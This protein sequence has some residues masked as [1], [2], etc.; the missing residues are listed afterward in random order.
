MSAE[1]NKALEDI[2][3]EGLNGEEIWKALYNKELNCKKNILEYIDLTRLLKKG[4]AQDH[5]LEDTYS[6]IYTKIE[7]M[8]ANIKPNTSMYLKNQLKKQ[9]GK[10]VIE[11]DPKPVNHFI[12]FFKDAYP[13]N[14]RR[15]DF[16]WVLMDIN[17]I[18]DEQLWTTLTYINRICIRAS[19]NFDQ[20]EK[21]DIIAA[22]ELL[23][24]RNNIKYINQIKSLD[25]LTTILNIKI[26]PLGDQ[27]EVK[28]R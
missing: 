11:K 19:I 2:N 14:E 21:K 15:K 8:G 27:F 18:T 4:K 22:I 25:K 6:F 12:E 13:P 20:D 7:E 1:V 10:Y 23:V 17:N 3:L 24:K 9:L 28:K 26:A 16:T 5:Q